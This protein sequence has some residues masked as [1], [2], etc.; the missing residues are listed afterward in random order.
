[1]DIPITQITEML[2]LVLI[3][4]IVATPLLILN[5]KV[6]PKLGMIDWPKA[7]GLAE[8]Q[9]PIVGHSLVLFSI[10]ILSLLGTFYRVSP[11]FITTA[12]L[13]AVM[14]HLDDR[15]P[16]S[17]V[18]KIFFQLICVLAV[19]YLDPKLHENLV[20][21]YG[22]WG[23]FWGIFFILGLMNAINFVDGIDGL[24]GI[25]IIVGAAGMVSF[26]L[27][28]NENYPNF[29]YGALLMGMMFP[30]LYFNVL[31]RKGFLGNVG[32]YF[33]SYVLAVMHLSAPLPSTNVLSRLSISALCFLIPVADSIM[34]ISSRSL[35]FRSPFKADKGHLHHRLIQTSIALRYILLNFAL[36][37][38]SGFSIAFLLSRQKGMGSSIM[39]VFLCLSYVTISTILILMVE[40]AS[41]K[42]LQSYFHRL[43]NGEPIYFLKYELVHTKGKTISAALLRR[44]EAKVSA[45]IRITDLCFAEK[46]N[47]LFVTL[48]TLAEP[49]KGISSR[50]DSVFQSEDV[51]TRVVIDQGEFV[52]VSYNSDPASRPAPSVLKRA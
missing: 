46:P 47:V 3:G 22:N 40:K 51:V 42:R 30:F 34:V 44:L 4:G 8:D 28:P 18:D 36:I 13:M 1:M 45:E 50:L 11:W 20:V 24:A 31:K 39:P 12:L 49:L 21:R 32:S 48:R 23:V 43:D 7:R 33:F 37:E 16:L 5:I 15:K 19:I 38:V 9:I 29:I 35:T 2:A 25:V 41:K 17:A 26:C 6:A 10:L 27:G 14:G 52:K